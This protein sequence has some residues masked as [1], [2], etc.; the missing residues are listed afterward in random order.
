[1]IGETGSVGD[2]EL[3][4]KLL[5]GFSSITHPVDQITEPVQ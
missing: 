5:N 4:T 2:E 1:M 3:K